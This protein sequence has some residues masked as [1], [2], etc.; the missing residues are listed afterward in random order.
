VVALMKRGEI[1]TANL[2]PNRGGEIGKIRPVLILQADAI[3][4]QG[5]RT[6]LV[7]PLTTQMRQ[8][9]EPLR[10]AIRARDR[11]L[12]D[13]HV[14][15]EHLNALDRTRFGDGPLAT[16]TAEEMATVEKSLRGFW[17]CGEGKTPIPA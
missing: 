17:G 7:A 15:L 9:F 16:L 11:L 5:L 8:E 4:G 3:T 10:V 6:I 13:C 2:N 14:M 1:W 12:Q